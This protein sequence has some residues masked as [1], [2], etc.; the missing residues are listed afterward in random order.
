MTL[1]LFVLVVSPIVMSATLSRQSASAS[2]PIE[3]PVVVNT[4]IKSVRI[5]TQPRVGRLTEA[6]AQAANWSGANFIYSTRG[7]GIYL[8]ELFG[9]LNDWTGRWVVKV[10]SREVN[11]L[12]TVQLQAGDEVNIQ[13]WRS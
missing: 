10:N 1:V 6:I 9:Q 11:D 7:S 5:V 12:N 13:R 3:V 2:T 4:G 8:R